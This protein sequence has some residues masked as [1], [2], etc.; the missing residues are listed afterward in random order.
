M[1]GI[2]GLRTQLQWRGLAGPAADV[3]RDV[4]L[5]SIYS[6]CACLHNTGVAPLP[7]AP[8]FCR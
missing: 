2:I 4:R 8:V 1:G 5:C 7:V 3:S 6:R